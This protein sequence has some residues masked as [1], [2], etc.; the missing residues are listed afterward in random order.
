MTKHALLI[1]FGP[2]LATGLVKAFGAQGFA[3]SLVARDQA[4][5][6]AA[7]ATL[8]PSGIS[9]LPYA[10]DAYQPASVV[11]A[12]QQARA[13]SGPFDLLL[14]NAAALKMRNLLEEDSTSLAHDL[15]ATVGSFLDVVKIA[16]PDLEARGGAALATGGGLGITPD[17]R[18]GSLA[19]GKAGL[20]NVVLQLHGLLKPRGVYVGSVVI[21]GFIQP[22]DPVYAPD[23]LA[24]HFVR[25]AAE[26]DVAEHIV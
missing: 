16:L 17:P 21:G 2:G 19:I 18:F 6:A 25:L 13:A 3:F 14:Y 9:A 1:G 7:I 15:N 8:K 11:A 5:L 10:G 4:K 22:S 20:R 26:R 24:Q 12:A 23:A